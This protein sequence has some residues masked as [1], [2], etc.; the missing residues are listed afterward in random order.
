MYDLTYEIIQHAVILSRAESITEV[1]AL[2]QR[3]EEL[4][5]D[6][7]F[8]VDEALMFWADQSAGSVVAASPDIQQRASAAV[9]P[10]GYAAKSF[11]GR[12]VL[13]LDGIP[14]R[15]KKTAAGSAMVKLASLGMKSDL[16]Q[17]GKRTSFYVLL[18]PSF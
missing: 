11:A 14:V 2:Q 16:R 3:L 15:L 17:S 4:Y 7:E 10:L 18:R 6:N 12:L 5:P 8:E 13:A 9:A 1:A